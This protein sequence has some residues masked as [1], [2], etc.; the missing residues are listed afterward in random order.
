[1][2]RKI[3]LVTGV[4]PGTGSSIVRRFASGGYS[5]IMV[6][7]SE[8]RLNKL[9]KQ[10]E[11][12]FSYPCDVSSETNFTKTIEEIKQK[13]GIPDV[14]IHNAVRGGRGNFMEIKP[15]DLLKNFEINAMGLLYLVRGFA[16]G[17]INRGSGSV[18]VTG[19][20]SAKRGKSW[21]ANTAPTK[22]AQRILAESMARELGPKG[23][24]VAYLLIDAVIDLDW[25]RKMWKDKEDDFFIKPDSIAD[26]AWHLSHQ[27]K[28]AWT[29]ETT[30]RPF[31]ESW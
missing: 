11:N 31:G 16:K 8:D 10:I 5:V 25:T 19:N 29:F 14:L 3:C 23:I 30:V 20:T 1:M 27:E 9:E 2:G 4:G 7:R 6:S 15:K 26:E 22:A 12:T 18:I 17:M 13:E 21:F 24:H 28:S